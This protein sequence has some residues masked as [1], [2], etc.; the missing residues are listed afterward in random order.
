M[1]PL[2]RAAL[3]E[4]FGTFILIV[5]GLGVVAQT[6]LSGQAAGSPLAIHLCWGIAVVLGVYACGGVSGAHINPAVTLDFAV[7]RGFPWA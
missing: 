1:T 7:R 6:V 2:A 3:A 5:F 4:F